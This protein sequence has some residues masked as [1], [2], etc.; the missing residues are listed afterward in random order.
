LRDIEDLAKKLSAL[1]HPTRIRI[2]MELTKGE[3]YLSEVAKN[4]GISRALAKVHLKKLR[5]SGLVESRI[6]TMEEEAR[7]LRFYKIL[8]F[9]FNISTESLAREVKE[10]EK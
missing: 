5:A 1:G 4:V 8:D 9:S 6:L 10:N 2:L 3:N 7:A